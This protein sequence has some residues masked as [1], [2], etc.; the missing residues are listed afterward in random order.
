[1]PLSL[2]RRSVLVAA[3]ALS[4]GVAASAAELR[5]MTSGTF[6]GAYLAL[7]P[8]CATARGDTV[9]TVTTSMGTG[10]AS[11]PSRLQRREPA[12][13][14]IVDRDALN[15]LIS[16]GAVRPGS[17]V[18][19]A[20]SA[21]GMAVR[22]GTPKPEIS[23][24]DGF[25]RTLLA[26][27][28]VA[29]S[30]SVS[31]DYLSS[32]LFERLGVASEVR[33]KSRRIVGER[34]GAVVARGDAEIGFQ[35]ISE[36]LPIKGIEY[37]GALPPELQKMTVVSAGLAAGTALPEQATAFIGCLA[38]R[39]AAAFIAR[40]GLEPRHEVAE[41]RPEFRALARLGPFFEK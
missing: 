7:I 24:A 23:T 10:D 3:L 21:I 14:V 27:A 9:V 32:E 18:D 5:V 36:L 19:L 26:A 1:M 16:Q 22:A 35:Q 34:V 25:R 37:V 38:S 2:T 31:G 15:N 40:S 12:D 4:L 29:Y 8:S 41:L 13:V 6:T 20:R 33:P 30:A 17:R 11:I 28:S 39:E